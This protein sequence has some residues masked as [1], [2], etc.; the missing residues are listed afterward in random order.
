MPL[1]TRIG[2]LHPP[3]L[4]Y[5]VSKSNARDGDVEKSV[6]DAVAGG[7]TMVQLRDASLPAGELLSLARRLK[8]ITRGKALLIIHDRVDVAIAVEADG[9]QLPEAGLPT[10][11]ARGLI[12]KYAV[13]GRSINDVEDAQRAT[14]EGAEFVV[15]GPIHQSESE[16]EVEPIG[17]GL[18]GEITKDSSL[19]V[20]AYGGIVAGNI[21]ELI[22]LGA[23][24]VAV[25]SAIARAE[26]AKAA[27]EEL[28]K[29]LRDAWTA[30]LSA[31]M[32]AA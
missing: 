13:L 25:T 5:V 3:V 1:P 31:A 11:T 4:C 32:G 20:L 14:R 12:G 19:S 24:G 27:A 23:A 2:R 8:A 15:A 10:L 21:E 26:D 7:V 29:V 22:S 18:I 28:L 6:A 30:R 9:V 16:P 17:P